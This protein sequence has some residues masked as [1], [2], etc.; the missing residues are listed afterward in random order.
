LPLAILHVRKAFTLVELL[1][2]IA[3]I[4][5]LA[6]LLLPALAGAKLQGQQTQCVSNLKQIG[7]AQR[8]YYDDYG[9]FSTVWQ[10]TFD[11][12]DASWHWLLL[13]PYGLGGRVD[14]C[15]SA[16]DTNGQ[17]FEEGSSTTVPFAYSVELGWGDAGHAWIFSWLA[18]SVNELNSTQPFTNQLFNGSYALNSWLSLPT[19]S[20]PLGPPGHPVAPPG[21]QF[22]KTG[23][24]H[25]AQT[26]V[27]LD[28]SLPAEAPNSTNLP[29]GDL[30]V[31]FPIARHGAKPAAAA[32]Q[33]WNISQRMPGMIDV[34]FFDGHVEK[35]QLENLWNYYWSVD[36]VVPNPR[37][38]LL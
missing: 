7:L 22:A 37:P 13:V 14:L 27:F 9:Y 10:G 33:Q 6:A 3:V 26:P 28:D 20:T 36:W 4:A 15:P 34:S 12:G 23:P 35:S 29:S 38:G 1:V 8:L 16:T 11:P 25:P 30:L 32:P 2:T 18:H 31:G 24:P 17:G 21:P 19:G 5:I